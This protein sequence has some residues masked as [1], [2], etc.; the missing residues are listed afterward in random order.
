MKFLKSKF[1]VDDGDFL[2]AL[3][4][5]FFVL[6]FTAG[7]PSFIFYFAVQ[8]KLSV[9]WGFYLPII[10]IVSTSA[11]FFLMI[12]FQIWGHLWKFLDDGVEVNNILFNIIYDK[13]ISPVK[14]TI[15][16]SLIPI[17]V[18][19]GIKFYVICLILFVL[20]LLAHVARMIIRLVKRFNLHEKNVNAHKEVSE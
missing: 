5:A 17:I 10:N 16:N 8:V 7:I 11:L 18:V 2:N 12:I 9:F 3:T 20:Y 6:I 1:G 19:L 15:F 4:L 14:L 13:D